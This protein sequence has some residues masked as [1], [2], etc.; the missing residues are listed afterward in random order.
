MTGKGAEMALELFTQFMAWATAINVGLF[1]ITALSVMMV[2]GPISQI[3]ARM[4]GLEAPDVRRTY[5]GY[6][7]VY[8][9]LVV[10]FFLVPYLALRFGMG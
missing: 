1:V 8:K 10:V 4:F 2:G 9:I 5:F 7:S 3:H 6:L